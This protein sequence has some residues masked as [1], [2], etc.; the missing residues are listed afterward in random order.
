V[1]ERL[2]V[3]FGVLIPSYALMDFDISTGQPVDWQRLHNENL[4]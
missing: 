4:D 1:V 2:R 3:G